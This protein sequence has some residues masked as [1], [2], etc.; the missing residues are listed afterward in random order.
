[1]ATT[2]ENPKQPAP[3]ESANRAGLASVAP[4]A[5]AEPG[6]PVTP[7]VPASLAEVVDQSKQVQEK[8]EECVSELSMVNGLLDEKVAVK[9]PLKEIKAAISQNKEIEL[10]I[11]DCA[12]ELATINVILKDEIRER[13]ALDI[14]LAVS[15]N[16]L[17]VNRAAAAAATHRSLHDS[18]TGLPNASLFNDRLMIALKQAKRHGWQLAVMFIDLDKFKDINDRFGHDAGDRVLQAIGKCLQALVRSGD[19]ISRRSGDEF[20]L[21]TLEAGNKADVAALARKIIASIGRDCALPAT[22]IRVRPSIGI[23]LCPA[24]GSTAAELLAKADRAM[25]AAKH[26]PEGFAFFGRPRTG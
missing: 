14:E 11:Q 16:A 25:Y 22:D 4:D 8:V 26:D 24:D 19:S 17:Q 10:K 7:P 1:L 15:A 6:A 23:A 3:D 12:D 2:E 13:A 5:A 9:L 21:L 18:L 20:L